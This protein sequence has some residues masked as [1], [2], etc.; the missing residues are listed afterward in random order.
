M[1][2]SS[3][4]RWRPR[5]AR[6]HRRTRK[7]PCRKPGTRRALFYSQAR[8]LDGF[9]FQDPYRRAPPA[10][11]DNIRAVFRR[12]ASPLVFIFV[13]VFVNFMGYGMVVPLMPLYVQQQS[14][15]AA[16]VGALGA[17]YAVMELVA[18]PVIGALSDRLGR[19]PVLIACVTGTLIAYIMLGLAQSLTVIFLAVALDGITG[20]TL[21][22]AYAYVADVTTPENR[23]RGMGMVGAAFGLGVIAGPAFGGLLS[24]Y[25]LALPALIA[26]SVAG[27]NILF[28][29]LVLPESLPRERRAATPALQTFNWAGQVTNLLRILP[30]RSL[31]VGMFLLNLAFAGLQNNFPLYS[32]VRFGW[33]PTENGGFFAF[34]GICAVLIQGLLYGRIQPRF[35]ERNLARAGLLFMAIGLAGMALAPEPWMLFP[36]VAVV[37]LGTGTAIPSLTGLVSQRLPSGAQGRLMGGTQAILGL[38]M[39]GGPLFSGLAFEQI[40][41]AAPY[42][43]G[44]VLA[45][46][47]LTV[48]NRDAQD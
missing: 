41:P 18:S 16:V 26:A 30:I 28:G 29:L 17:T 15:G 2:K 39:I 12:R 47:A 13:A 21:A 23:A 31:L 43:L 46:V 25:G 5:K 9:C 14:G 24:Q 22:T 34:V 42:A 3:P 44:A 4:P 40:A 7:A 32:Q 11:S 19:R 10:G 35:G 33:T 1:D 8:I 27:A 36:S 6:R 37:A 20:G 45:L 38:A 48:V